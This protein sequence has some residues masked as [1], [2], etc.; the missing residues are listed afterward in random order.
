MPDHEPQRLIEIFVDKTANP[1]HRAEAARRLAELDAPGALA[2]LI[3]IARDHE[4]D[5]AV[6]R[7]AGAAVARLLIRRGELDQGPLEDFTGGA[8]LGYD[9]P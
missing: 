4:V 9:E 8:Y 1:G 2:A 7:A 3:Q 6:S 5:N